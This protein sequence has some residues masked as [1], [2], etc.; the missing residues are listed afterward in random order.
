MTVDVFS[1]VTAGVTVHPGTVS[2][3]NQTI[4]YAQR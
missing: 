1:T 2:T 3:T 4:V